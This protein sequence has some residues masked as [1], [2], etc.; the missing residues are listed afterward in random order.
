MDVLSLIGS[1]INRNNSNDNKETSKRN[2]GNTRPIKNLFLGNGK[3]GVT[4]LLYQ[5]L[6]LPEQFV[7]L[8]S[9][10]NILSSKLH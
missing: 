2:L 3:S 8:L 4:N 5:L 6:Y 7:P 9:I 10:C 1:V